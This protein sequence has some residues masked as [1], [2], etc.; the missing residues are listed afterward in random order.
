MFVQCLRMYSAVH[1][2]ARAAALRCVY[3]SR[4]CLERMRIGHR[5]I[6]AR[7][8]PTVRGRQRCTTA[9]A[10]CPATR[11]ACWH[12]RAAPQ[13]GPGPRP[14]RRCAAAA[15][16]AGGAA[17][18]QRPQRRPPTAVCRPRAARAAHARWSGAPPPARRP[19]RG[20]TGRAPTGAAGPMRRAAAAAAQPLLPGLAAARHLPVAP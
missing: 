2:Q 4:R 1:V 15:G 11:R 13:L 16:P 8:S 17:R 14:L 12:A 19:R 5:C 3:R 10:E 20:P 18:A 9:A 7:S 6:T